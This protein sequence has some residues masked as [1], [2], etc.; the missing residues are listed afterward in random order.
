MKTV[1]I[2]GANRGFGE[3]LLTCFE[4]AGWHVLATARRPETL[5]TRERVTPL[6]LDLSNKQSIAALADAV[7]S[8]GYTVDLLIN[9]AG[10]N[11]KDS[12]DKA[13]F[14]S[15]FKIAH[16]SGRNVAKS[17][18]INALAPMELSS[19]LLPSLAENAV[20]LNISSWLGSI[21]AKSGGG[22]YG[23]SGSKAL[24]NMFT[25]AMALEFAE[26]Q[27]AAVAFNPGWMRTDM[28]GDKAQVSPADVAQAVLDLYSEG[29]LHQNNGEFLNFDGS[30][31]VW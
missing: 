21:G 3:A 9:N 23:Y 24:L 27:R 10:Y 19:K 7:K 20:V 25:R 17:L 8:A 16:F 12:S 5:P 15:T 13:Y 28:G 2:T 30:R 1:L 14:M 29:A 22:H 26:G 18:E 4:G 6:T 31:H 11:P